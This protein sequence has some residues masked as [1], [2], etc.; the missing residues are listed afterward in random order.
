MLDPPHSLR[1]LGS[2]RGKHK[3]L[4]PAIASQAAAG[5]GTEDHRVDRTAEM[6]D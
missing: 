4:P 6:R 2:A 1:K 3:D 5:P